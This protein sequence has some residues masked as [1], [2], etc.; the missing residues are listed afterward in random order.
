MVYVFNPGLLYLRF[1]PIPE[2]TVYEANSDILQVNHNMPLN[3]Q[4]SVFPGSYF[5]NNLNDSSD[6][7]VGEKQNE[8][9]YK[10]LITI[11]IYGPA[12]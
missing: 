4:Y 7:C 10:H 12:L 1:H 6:I 11:E 2:L 9:R 5:F 3:K 8:R